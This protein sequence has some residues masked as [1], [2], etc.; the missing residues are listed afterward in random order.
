M[1]VKLVAKCRSAV[2]EQPGGRVRDFR[3]DSVA[4]QDDDFLLDTAH[5]RLPRSRHISWD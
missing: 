2:N 1:E 4:R 5:V 3:T